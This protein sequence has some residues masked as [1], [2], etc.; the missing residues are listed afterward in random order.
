MRED[1][2]GWNHEIINRKSK[3]SNGFNFHED[4]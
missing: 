2:C 4:Y 3:I 1:V